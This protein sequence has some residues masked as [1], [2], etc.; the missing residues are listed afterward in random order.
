MEVVLTDDADTRAQFPFGF[1]VRVTYRVSRGRVEL[2]HL[3]K[4][5]EANTEAM[6]FSIGNHIALAVPLV[7][8]SS[9]EARM[10]FRTVRPAAEAFFRPCF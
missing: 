8:G 5:A 1:E 9:A 4:A 6:F 2:E 7:G 10:V 3:V